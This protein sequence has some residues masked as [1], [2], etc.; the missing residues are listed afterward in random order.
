MLLELLFNFWPSGSYITNKVENFSYTKNLNR[1]SLTLKRDEMTEKSII[2]GEQHAN[3]R[4]EAEKYG[5][6]KQLE[7]ILEKLH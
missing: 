7:R 3:V 1:K 6:Q 4:A 5:N 2:A